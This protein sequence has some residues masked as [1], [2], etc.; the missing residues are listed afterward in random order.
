MSA[1]RRNGALTFTFAGL[2]YTYPGDDDIG[3]FEVKAG[4]SWTGG[5]W[6][7]GVNNY[8]SPDNFQFLA[9]RMRS[10]ERSAMPGME[11][12]EFLHAQH[13][14]PL[15][16]SSRT[17]I[18]AGDYTYWNAGLTLGF[19]DHWSADIRYYDTDYNKDECFATEWWAE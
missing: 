4:A 13:Q 10:R 16:A 19:L 12:V 5:A 7:L 1:S 17:K 14:R 11:A 8:W 3:Y 6:T 9:S 18:N 15:S 2:Y